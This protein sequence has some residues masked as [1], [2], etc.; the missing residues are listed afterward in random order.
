[1]TFY[2][3]AGLIALLALAAAVYGALPSPSAA[4]TEQTPTVIVQLTKLKKGSLPR[5]LTAFGRVEPGPSARQTI[6]APLAAVVD[7]V[8]VKAGE[9]VAA[10]APLVR[11]GPSPATAASFS[12]AESALRVA[13]E[14]ERRT[15]S[16]LAQHLAT[17]QQ[18]ADAGKAVSDAQSSLDAL[19]AEGASSPQVVKA[20]GPAIVT[21]VS[22]SLGAIVTSGTALLDLAR[23]G[24]LLLRVGLT[25]EQ[26]ATVQPGNKAR[27]TPLGASVV[28][29]GHVLLRGS[30]IDAQTGLVPVD[31]TLPASGGPLPGEMAE[32]AITTGQVDGYV[33]P[34][35][36]VL[37]DPKGDTYLVE[38]KDDVA[39]RV[40]VRVLLAAGDRDVVAGALDGTASLVLAG[41]YQ[42]EDG[43][44]VRSATAKPGAGR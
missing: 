10:D 40:P 3:L 41:N 31:I 35:A 14:T 11:L 23:P 13:R 16:L 22:T 12:Q 21:A 17:A 20:P 27:I 34:H 33:V 15:R 26:A 30:M 44:R 18:L 9:E 8:Y 38:A 19:R 24:S 7:Q 1:M 28:I 4:P 2:R 6:Q 25:P 36:A 43:M 29:D 32:A 37:V 5:V 42:L 39:H